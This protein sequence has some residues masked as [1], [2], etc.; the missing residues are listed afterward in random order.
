MLLLPSLIKINFMS[1]LV[2]F[3]F[4]SVAGC[5]ILHSN[6]LLCS[7]LCQPASYLAIP[8]R[9]VLF[10]SALSSPCLSCEREHGVFRILFSTVQSITR[11]VWIDVK[12]DI[13]I[14]LL[15]MGH[16]L[17]PFF[18]LETL[19]HFSTCAFGILHDSALFEKN[20]TRSI[21]ISPGHFFI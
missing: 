13:Y 3:W 21:H 20:A 8:L 10:C 9:P 16:L 6:V 19:S 18:P 12:N 7:V 17:K 5:T 14:H 11:S 2:L 4:F 1:C 15:F